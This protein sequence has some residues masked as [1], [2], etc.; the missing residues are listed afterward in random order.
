MGIFPRSLKGAR[1]RVEPRIVAAS[2]E[3]PA[4]PLS[5]PHAWLLDY[6]PT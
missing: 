1:Q 5:N 2:P 4:T 6:T 3:N